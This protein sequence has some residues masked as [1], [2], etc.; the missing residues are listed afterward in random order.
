MK[1]KL[2]L[3]AAVICALCA[4][5]CARKPAGLK[6]H[7]PAELYQ[8]VTSFYDYLGTRELDSYEDKEEIQARFEDQ[9]EYYAFL[10]TML[11]AMWDRK[12]ERNRITGYQV[13]AITL[14]EDQTEAW[15]KI[16]IKSD[17]TLPFGKVMTYSQR[18]YSRK[19]N[20]YPAEIKAP[21]VNI[22]E[23]YR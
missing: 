1:R 5:G 2:L 22:L 7:E 13:L 17:D 6:T 20:W 4:A 3:T 11:P 14:N 23:K 16:W 19:F 21:R 12:F 8:T 10:D 9:S 15:V 18:F